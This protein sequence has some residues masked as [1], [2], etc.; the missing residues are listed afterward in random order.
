MRLLFIVLFLIYINP[1]FSQEKKNTTSTENNQTKFYIE[2]AKNYFEE[3]K[4]YNSENPDSAVIYRNYIRKSLQYYEKA[5]DTSHHPYYNLLLGISLFLEY[6]LDSA[7]VYFKQALETYQK[8]PDIPENNTKK[9]AYILTTHSYKALGEHD[10][11]LMYGYKLIDFAQEINDSSTVADYLWTVA[12]IYR[13]MGQTSD[14]LKHFIMSAQMAKCIKNYKHVRSSYDGASGIYNTLGDYQQAL[15]MIDSAMKYVKIAGNTADLGKVLISAGE[16]YYN[17]KRYDKAIEAYEEAMQYLKEAGEEQLYKATRSALTLVL[18]EAGKQNLASKNVIASMSDEDIDFS[19][20]S[21]AIPGSYQ[22]LKLQLLTSNVNAEDKKIKFDILHQEYLERQA[23][24][25]RQRIWF[26]SLLSGLIIILLLL[27]YNRQR[28]KA[29]IESAARYAEEKENEY[30]SLQKETELRMIR[31]YI[32]GLEHERSRISKELHDGVCNDLLALEIELKN[33][34]KNVDKQT[35]FL[36]KTRENIRHV[37]HELMPPAFQY[38]TIDEIL[39]DYISH[40]HSSENIKI[41]YS[42]TENKDWNNIPQK[43]AFEVYRITQETLSNSIKHA[44]ANKINIS[45]TIENDKLIL[46]VRDNGTGF[47]QSGKN[48][49]AGLNIISER[50]ESI[51]G[52]LY[53]TTDTKGTIVKAIF[54]LK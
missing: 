37:S 11:A 44:K 50:V 3:G 39:S 53:I 1:S 18:S 4:L 46:E 2:Q 6:K 35:A 28:Q 34:G 21:L 29:K 51:G 17:L 36:S 42:Q 26:I 48:K 25:L 33:S 23:E 16:I 41:Q 32:D 9:R 7:I 27:L 13:D 15:S 38:A 30:L 40:F 24:S 49:G 14:A 45:L 54:S 22:D 12:T 8:S 47:D 52:R 43:T 20:D 10:S 31:K 19:S 5:G